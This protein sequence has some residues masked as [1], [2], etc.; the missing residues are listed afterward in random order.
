VT[1]GDFRAW[2]ARLR[3]TQAEA[4]ELLG[5]HRNTV[6]LYEQGV[7]RDRRTPVAIP[8]LVERACRD[9]ERELLE[10]VRGAGSSGR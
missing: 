7:R 2:R 1:P 8:K 4:A 9:V 3:L 10:R 5:I 6:A